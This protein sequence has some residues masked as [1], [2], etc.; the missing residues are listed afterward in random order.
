MELQEWELRELEKIRQSRKSLE[1]LYYESVSIPEKAELLEQMKVKGENPDRIQIID[2]LYKHRYIKGGKGVENVDVAIR[3][4]V[5]INF[6]ADMAKGMFAKRKIPK[7]IEEILEDL[8]MNVCTKYG[9]LGKEIWKKELISVVSFYIHLCQTD[10]AYTSIL[11]GIGHIKPEKLQRKICYDVVKTIHAIPRDIG[12]DKFSELEDAG[13][14]AFKNAY[15]D[16]GNL[17]EAM[18]EKV[19]K[20]GYTIEN[21]EQLK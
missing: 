3:G 19:D 12:T 9:D 2:E 18:I 5:N 4:W 7:K 10:K 15:P 11:F 1:T 21:D 14:I 17:I 16:S 6:L 20:N 13:I 8:G